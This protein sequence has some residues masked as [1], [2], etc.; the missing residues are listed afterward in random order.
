MSSSNRTTLAQLDKMTAEEVKTIPLSHLKL[1]VEDLA[2]KAAIHK[3]RDAKIYAEM[4]RRFAVP[5][6]EA[7]KAD[8]RDTGTVHV[9]MEG[10]RIKADLPKKPEYDQKKLAAIALV[11]KDEWGGDVS[12]YIK[13]TLDVSETK[14]NAWPA[15]IR[16]LFEP[17]RTL[18]TGKATYKFE[19]EAA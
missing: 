4:D 9:E 14:Y 12:D 13:T 11:I 10:E 18:K 2:E 6:M 3:A 16:K 15:P 17:A 19:K 8:G 7:R 1:L 5:A